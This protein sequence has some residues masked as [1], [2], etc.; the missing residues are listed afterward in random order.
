MIYERIPCVLIRGG[1][2]RG[3]FFHEHDLPREASERRSMI[4]SAFGSPDRRQIDGL[5]G[6]TPETSKLAII[7]P[8]KHTRAQIDY[9]FAQVGIGEPTLNY[10]LNCGNLAAGAAIFAIDEGLVRPEEPL[11]TVSI[12]ST[13][14][15]TLCRARVEVRDGRAA[16]AGDFSIDGVP[17]RGSA[18]ELTFSNVAGAATGKLLPSGQSVDRIRPARGRPFDVSLVD[19]GNLY[20][21]VAAADLGL[22]GEEPAERLANDPALG[23]LARRIFAACTELV[24][25]DLS[26]AAPRVQKLAVVSP[27]LAASPCDLACRILSA[28]GTAHRTFA[29][30]GAIA[31]GFAA[32]IEGSVVHRALQGDPPS[33]LRIGHPQG[34]IPVAID[35][36]PQ[37][38]RRQPG[39]ARIWRTAR[40]LME[41]FV[42]VR[43]VRRDPAHAQRHAPTAEAAIAEGMR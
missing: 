29:V 35:C 43:R 41:G 21:L 31:I 37:A 30:T 22:T 40:R 10:S 38:G 20:A 11:T 28:D 8:S 25:A 33:P 6:A 12:L 32:F 3:L 7:A 2:S 14:S 16:T 42:W 1:T 19:A 5:G 18:I 39:T 27:R 24:G 36:E 13:N 15:Q 26:A 9:T 34:T 23:E 17:G 4:L